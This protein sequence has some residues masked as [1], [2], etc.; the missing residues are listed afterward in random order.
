MQRRMRTRWLIAGAS[1]VL[2]MMLTASLAF[3]AELLGGKVRTG[4]TVNVPAGEVVDHDLYLFAGTAT[5]DGTVN[6]DLVVIAGTITVHGPVS[7]EIIAA[8]GTIQLDGNVGG[9][10]RVGGES[11]S[12][13]L[14]RSGSGVAAEVRGAR[15]LATE[16]GR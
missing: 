8:G 11:I 7:G 3:G 2:L 4:N 16:V 12:I 14:R 5:M 1:L 9:A 15:H 13:S 10:V 6:G